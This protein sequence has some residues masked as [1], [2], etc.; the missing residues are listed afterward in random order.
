[1]DRVAYYQAT[2]SLQRK[3]RRAAALRRRVFLT[4]LVLLIATAFTAWPRSAE[5]N[6]TRLRVHHGETVQELLQ[7]AQLNLRVGDLLDVQGHVI[8]RGKGQPAVVFVDDRRARLDD[9]VKRGAR[10]WAVPAGDRVEPLRETATVLPREGS[11]SPEVPTIKR[12][13]RGRYSHL[14]AGVEVARATKIRPKRELRAPG[15][16]PQ[17]ALT[18]DDGPDSRWTP[19]ILKLLARYHAHATF[20]VLGL[21]AEQEPELL[22]RTVAAGHEI[23]NHSFGHDWLSKKSAD[24]IRQDLQRVEALVEPVTGYRIRWFRSPYGARNDTLRQVVSVL[25]YSEATWD[26]DPW[27]WKRPGADRICSRVL[28]AVD[29]GEVVLL[30][31]GGLNRAQTVEALGRILEALS[32]EGYEFVTL[33][34]LRPLGDPLVVSRVELAGG[35]LTVRECRP[36]LRVIVNG[37]EVTLRSRPAEAGNDLLLPARLLTQELGLALRYRDRQKACALETPGGIVTARVSSRRVDW[38]GRTEALEVPPLFFRG[39]LVLPL[40]L[41]CEAGGVLADYEA[42]TRTLRLALPE[43][44]GLPTTPLPRPAAGAP[45]RLGWDQPWPEALARRAALCGAPPTEASFRGR[46]PGV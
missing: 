9:H 17:I 41:V 8:G 1:M 32:E 6:G 42:A 24:Y 35:P 25:G 23:G 39:D 2:R 31:D 40:W 4:L 3:R 44:A 10:I 16:R 45:R 43:C 15:G 19:Q 27:D 12:A 11:A 7:R 29:P 5:V 36:G 21:R 14:L 13:W 34:E 26:V 46:L 18:F 33:S 38:C 30:H 28:N 22:R 37:R 20:F